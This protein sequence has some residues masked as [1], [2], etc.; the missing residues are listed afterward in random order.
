MAKTDTKPETAVESAQVALDAAKLISD[1]GERATAVQ[2]AK[3]TLN[4][5]RRGGK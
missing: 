5:A 2:A 4:A 3:E 1:R